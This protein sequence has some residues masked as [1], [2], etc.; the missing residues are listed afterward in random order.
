MNN[1]A[2]F[3][4]ANEQPGYRRLPRAEYIQRAHE[5]APRGE[6]LSKKLTAGDVKKIRANV[7]G[8]TD[9]QQGAL[10]GVSASMVYKIRKRERWGCL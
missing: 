6:K 4:R 9:K 2:N 1:T 3:R 7:Y 5:Y 10:Y 8:L